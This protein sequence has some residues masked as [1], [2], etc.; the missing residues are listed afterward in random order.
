MRNRS[1]CLR[2][3]VGI[4][5]LLPSIAS[6]A[7]G[8]PPTG[9]CCLVDGNCVETIEVD[10]NAPNANWMG[11]NT[12]CSVDLC[13]GACFFPS[14]SGEGCALGIF[15]GCGCCLDAE[16]CQ[17]LEGDFAG[18]GTTCSSVPMGACCLE[19]GCF[20]THRSLC[21]DFGGQWH[22]GQSCPGPCGGACC[23]L[24]SS[25]IDSDHPL[26]TTS[27]PLSKCLCESLFGGV[28]QGESTCC[29]DP[30]PEIACPQPR[31]ACCL[32]FPGLSSGCTDGMTEFQCAYDRGQ[33]QGNYTLCSNATCPR[34]PCP[35]TEPC[36]EIHRSAG[37]EDPECCTRVCTIDPACCFVSFFDT[38]EWGPIC[39]KKASQICGNGG[40]Y[41]PIPQDFDANLHVDLKDYAVFQRAFSG[42]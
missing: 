23:V 16:S 31:G 24:G 2:F 28:F 39:V 25:C 42:P 10:C 26:A 1:R 18:L 27:V 30:V 41:C 40:P 37:C 22:G 5:V 3:I 20:Y 7:Q 9:A 33:F 29:T 11:P 12:A 15:D 19:A 38:P 34:G 8:P 17:A 32:P 35:G 13:V 21:D 36:C 14:I 6:F 4:C